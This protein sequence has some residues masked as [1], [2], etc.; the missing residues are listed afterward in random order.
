MNLLYIFGFILPVIAFIFEAYPRF[1]NRTCGVDIWTHLLYLKEFK[2]NNKIPGHIGGKFLVSGNYDY[3][4]AFILIMSRFPLHFVEK[5]E[6]LFSPF[7]DSIHVFLIYIISY[8]LSGSIFFSLLVQAI[9]VTTPIVVV[10]NSSATP[11]SLGYTLFT[12]TFV[13]LF[14]YQ[15]NSNLIYL[16]LAIISG[17][18]IFLSHRFTTQGFLFFSLIFGLIFN[19]FIYIKVFALSFVLAVVLSRGFYVRVLKGHLGNLRFWYQNIEFRFYH[20]IKGKLKKDKGSDFVLKMYN[21]FLRFPPFIL[22]ITNPWATV[23]VYFAV[24][25]L[26]KD[27]LGI[28][29]FWWLVI[30]YILAVITIWIPKLRFLGEGQRYFEL[31]AFPA[32]F[33]SVKILFQLFFEKSI[34][35]IPI[36]YLIIIILSVL[37]IIVIQRKAIINDNLRSLTPNLIK[38]FDYLK[39]LKLKPKLLC[40]PQQITTNTIYHTDCPVFVNADYANMGKIS[41][42]YP[43]LKKPVKDVLRKNNLDLILLNENFALIKD[44][45]IKNYKVIKKVGEYVLLKLYD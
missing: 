11:R 17:T 38:M 16:Y 3:P 41:D 13:S 32:A 45:K 40:F 9:Y 8:H 44:L 28:R 27:E 6:F 37:T 5:Y 30:S 10:E 29:F 26:P 15:N 1:I 7:F 14:I 36:V 39:S 21:R 43:Y 35:I 18:L 34:F 23:W 12:I 25:D 22:L 24:T 4:P 31:A 42:V 19:T 2:K 20:Q 33:L